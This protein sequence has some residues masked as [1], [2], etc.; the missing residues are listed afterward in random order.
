VLQS[1]LRINKQEI[2]NYRF[3]DVFKGQEASK[4]LIIW[5]N[6]YNNAALYFNKISKEKEIKELK[7]RID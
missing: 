4:L 6:K 7:E 5:L 2:T 1:F 3:N